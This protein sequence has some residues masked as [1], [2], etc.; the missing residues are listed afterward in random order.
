METTKPFYTLTG[1]FISH[2]SYAGKQ[3]T[4]TFSRGTMNKEK[5]VAALERC[6]AFYGERLLKV[7]LIE[8]TITF[9]N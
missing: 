6:K 9:T 4:N 8:G 5:A 7:E 3:L 2:Y 1:T